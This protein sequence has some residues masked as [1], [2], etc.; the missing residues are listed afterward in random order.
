[1]QEWRLLPLFEVLQHFYYYCIISLSLLNYDYSVCTHASK[2]CAFKHWYEIFPP[3]ISREKYHN[4]NWMFCHSSV[5]ALLHIC[6]FFFIYFWLLIRFKFTVSFII[7]KDIWVQQIWTPKNCC[8]DTTESRME[9]EWNWSVYWMVVIYNTVL[10]NW[11]WT[12]LYTGMVFVN[13][14]I[15]IFSLVCLWIHCYCVCVC[16]CVDKYI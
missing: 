13:K 2:Y 6:P 12:I 5:H 9:K 10:L 14:L 7:Y 4:C 11:L 8:A 15:W 16:L 1:M 3:N